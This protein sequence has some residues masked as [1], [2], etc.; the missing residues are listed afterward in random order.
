MRSAQKRVWITTAYFAPSHGLL[1]ALESAVDNG[2]D[3]RILVPRNSDIFFMPWVTR[4]YYSR[5]LKR[6]V[7]IYE[8]LPRF[9]HAKSAV[10]DDWALVGTTNL[11]RRSFAHDFEIDV[12]LSKVGSVEELATQF[13]VDLNSSE[14]IMV[15][16]GGVKAFLGRWVS[17]IFKNWI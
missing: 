7:K 8:Y 3:V 12:V 10:I 6:G 1:R 2:A 14:Q 13:L 11:N 15:P 17:L 5:L 9:L 16:A 4:A